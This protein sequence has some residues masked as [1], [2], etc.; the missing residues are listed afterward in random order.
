MIQKTNNTGYKPPILYKMPADKLTWKTV[1][2]LKETVFQYLEEGNHSELRV[3]LSDVE[4]IDVAGAVF[5]VEIKGRL[6]GGLE[7]I[8]VPDC[9]KHCLDITRLDNMLLGDSIPHNSH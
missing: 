5:L 1:H 6:S 8:G 2:S 3:D 9:V 4:E 7:L